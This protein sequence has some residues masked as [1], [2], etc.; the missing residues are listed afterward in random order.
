MAPLSIPVV[1]RAEILRLALGLIARDAVSLLQLAGELIAL[2][3]ELVDL[4]VGQLAPLLLHFS[5]DLL[6][7]ACGTVIVHLDTSKLDLEISEQSPCRLPTPGACCPASD[8]R[9]RQRPRPRPEPPRTA[10]A[11]SRPSHRPGSRARCCARD[12]RRCWSPEWR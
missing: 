7:L 5:L 6:P 8:T 12:S 9:H 10:T 1:A 4:I 11:D 2:A 3:L